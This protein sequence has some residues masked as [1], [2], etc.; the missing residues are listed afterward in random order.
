MT[1]D[2]IRMHPTFTI[3][4]VFVMLVYGHLTVNL[5]RAK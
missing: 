2:P 4:T 3:A 1:T 5:R